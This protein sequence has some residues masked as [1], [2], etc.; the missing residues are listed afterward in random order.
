MILYGAFLAPKYQLE[1]LRDDTLSTLGYVTNWRLIF[2]GQG[3]FEQ[4]AVPSPFRHA[5]SLA[6]E[7]QF[8]LVWPLVVYGLCRWLRLSWRAMGLLFA[9]LAFGSAALMAV[10]F[11]RAGVTRV[12][13]GTDTR[14]QALLIGAALAV[15]VPRQ[16]PA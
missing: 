7:E 8:Y 9:G 6:I 5:W 1:S 11:E 10:L 2:S 4:F 3:Y 12:Y 16:G 14:A 13:Y 15:V